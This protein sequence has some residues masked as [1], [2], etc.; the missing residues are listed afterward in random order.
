MLEHTRR[1]GRVPRE[2]QESPL[3]K[4]HEF[5][6]TQPVLHGEQK[7]E[8]NETIENKTLTDIEK[9]PLP[10]GHAG[11]E[12]SDTD[13]DDPVVLDQIYTLL[14]EN[15]VEDDDC[16]FRFDYSREFLLWALKPPGFR[17]EWHVGVRYGKA[18]RLMA[19]ITAVPANMCVRGTTIPMV[20][21]NFLCI[22]KQL[23]EH[24]LAPKLIKEI[25][26]R[27]N[28]TNIWQAVY[29]AG[30]KLPRPVGE[31]RY[32]HRSLNPKKLVNVGFSS[33]H[34]RLTIPRAVKLY[35]VDGRPHIPGLRAAKPEDVPQMAVLLREFLATRQLYPVFDDEEVAHWF[36]PRHDIINT[37]VVENP[38]TKKITDLLS[39]YS[40]PSSILGNDTYKTLRAAYSFYN[41]AT[42]VPLKELMSDALVMANQLGYDVFNCLDLMENK[43]FLAD[44]KF[45]PGDGNLHYYLFNWKCKAMQSS[46][47]GLVLM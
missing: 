38:G 22:H 43:S 6:D 5:W 23:R 27:V 44:L 21:I 2:Q 36:L 9:E 32:Y 46:E 14:K 3:D 7:E 8:A 28:L 13:V 17:R 31:C 41:V 40:L 45:G 35:R 37:F 20:E 42:S 34:S 19:F 4:P 39:F 24:R 47:L 33:L 18:K 16:M 29:T 26:R 10:F 30:V 11:F 12:W 25:T 15:Y 1:R